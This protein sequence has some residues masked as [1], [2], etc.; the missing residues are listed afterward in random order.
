[1]IGILLAL[2][3]G[4]PGSSAVEPPEETETETEAETEA[5]TE[6]ETET[7][8]DSADAGTPRLP[9][10]AEAARKAPPPPPPKDT[11]RPPGVPDDWIEI[12][13]APS[14]RED[15]D[16]ELIVW[17]TAAT[18]AARERLIQA[19]EDAGWTRK[20]R[21]RRGDIVFVGPEPWMGSAR[22]SDEGLLRF[23]RRAL[24]WTPVTPV[25]GPPQDGM[26]ALDPDYRASAGT[27]RGGLRGPVSLRKLEPHRQALREDVEAEIAALRRVLA[28]TSLR[29]SLAV[30]PDRLDALWEYGQSLDGGPA[31]QTPAERRAAVLDYWATRP[32]TREG[33]LALDTIQNWIV[34]VMQRSEHPA[35]PAELDAAAARRSDGRHPTGG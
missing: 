21:D 27:T 13:L 8:D 3:L 23:K 9:S 2:L 12:P 26:Q 29:Q 28:E 6:T 19:I 10:P 33:R 20:R 18:R 30:I 11:V 22:L 35:T 15:G 1:M 5:E 16:E 34:E 14:A 32:D 17:G 24:S 25:E 4:T 7:E 31:L